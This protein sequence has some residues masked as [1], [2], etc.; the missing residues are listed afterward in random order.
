MTSPN[1]NILLASE[2]YTDYLFSL[3]PK[4]L[5]TNYQLEKLLNG[6]NEENVE[7]RLTFMTENY[8]RA[9]YGYLY[10][11]I[12]YYSRIRPFQ[13]KSLGILFMRLNSVYPFD[14][15][16][17]DLFIDHPMFC[18]YLVRTGILEDEY[19]K[20]IT[21]DWEDWD[22]EELQRGY[23][24]STLEMAL[25]YDDI[26]E[27]QKVS[28][29]PSFSF[30]RTVDIYPSTPIEMMCFCAYYGAVKCMK[31]LMLN[32]KY[33]PQE[34]CPWA[35]SSGNVEIIRMLQTTGADMKNTLPNT[36]QYHWYEI[37]RWLFQNY[38]CE[39]LL[40][41]D[42]I[43]SYNTRALLFFLT[44][45]GQVD[46]ENEEGWTP[47]QAACVC[48]QYECCKYLISRGV[49]IEA[50]EYGENNIS[51]LIISSSR[52][53]SE[54][55]KLL[56]DSGADINY[57]GEDGWSAILSAAKNG[58]LNLVKYF[59]EKGAN[60]ESCN[61][62]NWTSLFM[63][64]FY[65]YHDMIK[66]LIDFGANVDAK[67]TEGETILDVCTSEE[68]KQEIIKLIEEKK[69]KQQQSSETNESKEPIEK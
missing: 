67:S 37:T 58:A 13:W 53:H 35:V 28:S 40:L 30:D 16:L 4:G 25:K 14:A 10:E 22:V 24:H 59:C 61:Y 47:L 63:A 57:Q 65:N 39:P 26:E 23:R 32:K 45:G 43:S 50:N 21:K 3:Y 49:S 42:C 48:G 8:S 29:S 20:Y 18:Q 44:Q 6:I 46:Q 2:Q 31:F 7:E 34:I 1:H 17:R 33:D 66:Y 5:K 38:D 64:A 51:P 27:L 69:T 62:S 41:S 68:T 12:S 11:I 56:V 19:Q 54:I 60:V 52:N 9:H 55:V 36:I 15:T